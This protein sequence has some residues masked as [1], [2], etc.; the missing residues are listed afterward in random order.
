MPLE[1][2]PMDA[3]AIAALYALR[4]TVKHEGR[5]M[6]LGPLPSGALLVR[7]ERDGRVWSIQDGTTVPV[8]GRETT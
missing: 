2:V 7:H 4:G 5:L 8:R 3:A 6:V 1:E